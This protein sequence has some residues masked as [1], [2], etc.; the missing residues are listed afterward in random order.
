VVFAVVVKKDTKEKTDGF[1]GGGGSYLWSV[2]LSLSKMEMRTAMFSEVVK[3]RLSGFP[4]GGGFLHVSC[5]VVVEGDIK[6]KTDGFP[7][8]FL[9][10][11]G[12]C[13]FVKGRR[14]KRTSSEVVKLRR[15]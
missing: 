9:H 1:T 3:V 5:A 13:E 14:T 4:G 10:V 8:G 12:G 6:A 7:G 11:V 15:Y 2:V